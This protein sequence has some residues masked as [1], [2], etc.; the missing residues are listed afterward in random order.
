MMA[1]FV[2]HVQ[3]ITGFVLGICNGSTSR[4][5]GVSIYSEQAMCHPSFAVPLELLQA[6]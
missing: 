1:H 5:S 2:S 4:I 6:S 3:L